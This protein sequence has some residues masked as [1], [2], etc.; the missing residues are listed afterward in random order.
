MLPKITVI[1]WQHSTKR[2]IWRVSK[3]NLS[4]PPILTVIVLS[5]LLK[6]NTLFI[7]INADYIDNAVNRF[8]TRIYKYFCFAIHNVFVFL[9]IIFLFV[10]L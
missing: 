6:V 7:I 2:Q 1:L 4:K 3:S 9:L 10:V 8:S 5:L